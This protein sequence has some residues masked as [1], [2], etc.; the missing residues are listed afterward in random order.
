MELGVAAGLV[1]GVTAAL[2]LT[3]TGD[4]VSGLA[5]DQ[6]PSTWQYVQV[7]G[8]LL[9][10]LLVLL[11]A[12][13]ATLAALSVRGTAPAVPAARRRRLAGV[14]LRGANLPCGKGHSLAKA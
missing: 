14:P 3:R 11:P 1:P 9:L 2:A 10:G 12:L 8:L 6:P 7:P 4:A 5:V 13:A